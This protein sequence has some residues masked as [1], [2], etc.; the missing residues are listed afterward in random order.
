MEQDK[1]MI[2]ERTLILDSH[3][4][5]KKLQRIAHQILE[6]HYKDKDIYIIG[7]VSDG[8]TIAERLC[9]ILKS[10]SELNIHCHSLKINKDKPLME[11]IEFSGELKSLKNKSVVLVDDVLNSGRTLIYAVQFLLNAEPRKLVTATLVDRIHRRFPIRADYV[12]LTLST[13]L[14]E[15]IAV[16]LGNDEDAVYLE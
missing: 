4:I 6:N 2:K 15:H 11:E 12:G 7:I 1:T 9:T 10:I 3:Q 14:K 8:Y 13:N 16:E 5:D